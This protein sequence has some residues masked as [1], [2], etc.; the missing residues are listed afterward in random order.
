MNKHNLSVLL[1]DDDDVALESTIRNLRKN[2]VHFPVLTAINGSEGLAVLREKRSSGTTS[3]SLIV[4]LDL[5]MPVMN[6]FE[7]LEELRRDPALR[8]TVVFVLTTSNTDVDRMHAYDECIAGYM[9]KSTIGPPFNNLANLLL[10]YDA[11]VQFP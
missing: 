5:N 10:S 3:E 7:F 11:V 1:I 8:P 2:A 6:G 4:L 9:L